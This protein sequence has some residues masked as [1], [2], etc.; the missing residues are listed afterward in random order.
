MLRVA[1]AFALMKARKLVRGRRSV[2]W[3]VRTGRVVAA[4]PHN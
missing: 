4:K 2:I 3:Q 1:I